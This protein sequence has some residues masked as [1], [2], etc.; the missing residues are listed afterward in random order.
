M[1]SRFRLAW[2]AGLLIGILAATSVSTAE[3]AGN[4]VARALAL[5]K[6]SLMLE[7]GGRA[8]IARQV[9]RPM[10]PASTMK[11][12][13]ALAAIQRWGLNHRFHTDFYRSDDGWLWVKGWGDPFLVS[14]EL[15]LIARALRREGVR[16]VAGIGADDTYFAAD[17]EIRGRSSSNNPYDAPVTALAANFNTVTLIKRGD[18]VSSGEAQT[19]ITPLARRFARGLG[20]GKHRVNLSEREPAVRYFGELIGAKLAANGI[21]VG[22]GRRVGFLPAG[23]KRVY[24]HRN[25]RDLRAVAKLA[26]NGIEVGEG[27]RVGFLPAGSK[28][29]Y[30]HRNSRDLRAVLSSMLEYSNN[31]I[32][33]DLFLLLGDRGDGRPIS[34]AQAQRTAADWAEE[35]FG[36][37]QFRIEDGAGLSRGNQLSARQLLQA[38]KA[39]APYRDLLPRQNGLV[40]AKTGTLRGVSTY[41]GFVN[42]KGRWEPFSLLINQPVDYGFRLQVANAL[43]E[44]PNIERYCPGASC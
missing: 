35:T 44:T 16:S 32:A 21:E 40:R 8:V 3:A 43:A 38:V 24:R 12:L 10:V 36:W 29:V 39:F 20:A 31:F 2:L 34:M 23:S 33:N 27:R 1:Q 19:P 9:D 37:R 26:A 13:T 17:V 11:I 7:E 14:E 42:R 25:S 30:R 22:E 18:R 4:P 41:A 6:A 15:D 5:P 28:R